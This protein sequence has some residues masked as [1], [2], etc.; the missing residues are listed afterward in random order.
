MPAVDPAGMFF[1][2]F[3]GIICADNAGKKKPELIVP[4][5]HVTWLFFS[6]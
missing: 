1:S 2:W 4:A 6:C 3:H 5:F